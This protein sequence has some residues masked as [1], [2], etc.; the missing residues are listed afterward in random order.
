[1]AVL[2]TLSTRDT[3]VLT[4]LFDPEA[5]PTAAE[6]LS[7]SELPNSPLTAEEL[8]HVKCLE[9]KAIRL[10]EKGLLEEAEEILSQAIQKYPNGLPSLLNN[11]AQVRRMLRNVG[12]AL[13]DLSRAIQIATPSDP[14]SFS[15]ANAKILSDAHI[16]R[17]TI[18][19]LL[20]RGE[21]GDMSVPETESSEKLMEYASR[22]FSIAGRYGNELARAMAV[23]TNPYAKMCGAIVETAL[24]KELHPLYNR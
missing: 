9:K 20:A 18:Y 17:A 19:M 10:A 5:Q 11:R 14:S 3:G 13:N 4:L 12:G 15:Q 21:K 2:G 16:H 6:S 23:R 8:D 24:R 1:M 22:D 7:I